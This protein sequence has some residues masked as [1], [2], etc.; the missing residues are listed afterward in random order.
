M[1]EHLYAIDLGRCTI[2]DLYSEDDETQMATLISKNPAFYDICALYCWHEISYDY[3]LQWC[4][5]R[6]IPNKIFD[7]CLLRMEY[8]RMQQNIKL[9]RMRRIPVIGWLR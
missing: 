3:G 9:I 1:N 7:E 6:E 8:F 5:S 2:T 4:K